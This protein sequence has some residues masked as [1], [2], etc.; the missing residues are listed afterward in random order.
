MFVDEFPEVS[1]SFAR[2]G[3][4]RWDTL[5]TIFIKHRLTHTELIL[6]LRRLIFVDIWILGSVS[7]L[8]M[9]HSEGRSIEK[10]YY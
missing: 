5:Y 9:G 6:V 2:P 10:R 1:D 8:T 3:D 7:S 4:P